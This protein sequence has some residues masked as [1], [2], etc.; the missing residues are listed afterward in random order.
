MR[1]ALVIVVLLGLSI[2][3]RVADAAPIVNGAGILTGYT[4]VDVGGTSYDVQFVDSSCVSLFSGCDEP[5]DFDFDAAGAV[6]ASQALVDQVFGSGNSFD[7]DPSLTSGCTHPAQC[8]IWIPYSG[9]G[10]TNFARLAVNV[11]GDLPDSGI[12]SGIG[13]APLNYSALPEATY[14]VFTPA[15]T[16]VPEPSSL[17][18][19][20][21]GGLG[22]LARARRQRRPGQRS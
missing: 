1:N 22:V 11:S 7:T 14:A 12:G 21:S 13:N 3:P 17:L 4:N 2:A 6:T 18:L 16:A 9:N 15:A 8:S 5:S 10:I 20:G 19:L